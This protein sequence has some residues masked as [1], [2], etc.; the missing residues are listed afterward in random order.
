[1]RLIVITIPRTEPRASSLRT[2][3]S[4]TAMTGSRLVHERSEVYPGWYREAYLPGRYTHHVH[5]EAYTRVYTTLY[6]Y[7]MVHPWYTPLLYIHHLRYTQG[8][9]LPYMPP[10][11]CTVVYTSLICLPGCV[12]ECISLHLASQVCTVVYMPPSS[13]P[14]CTTVGILPS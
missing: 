8:V 9:N 3:M 4:G 5:R 11:V 14:V 10:R 12:Q 2:R 1:M 13:L 6:I 7:T